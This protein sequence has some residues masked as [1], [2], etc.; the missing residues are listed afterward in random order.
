MN[1]GLGINA[2]AGWGK[3]TTW[4]T[5]AARSAFL[6]IPPGE[7]LNNGLSYFQSKALNGAAVKKLYPGTS[8]A[9]GDLPCEF[10]F[11]GLEL[12]LKHLMGAASSAASGMGYKHTFTPTDDLMEG[13]GLTVE[14]YRDAPTTDSF[15]HLGCKIPKGVFKID[16]DAVLMLTSTLLGKSVELD[17]KSA[18]PTFPTA[19]S[20]L[21]TQLAVSTGTFTGTVDVFGGT[22]EIGNPLGEDRFNLAAGA[23]LKEPVRSA[24]RGVTISFD[25]EYG[26]EIQQTEWTAGTEGQLI[27]TWTGPEYATG[28]NYELVITANGQ[29]TARQPNVADEGPVKMPTTFQ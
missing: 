8:K 24:K 10:Q 7:S 13:E 14:V 28:E 23:V 16:R 9:A 2:W 17:T 18:A 12:L 15:L 1:P 20:A 26:E 3:E 29:F 6:E 5:K 21:Q 22:I 4:G 19:P 11:E 25:A 27:W